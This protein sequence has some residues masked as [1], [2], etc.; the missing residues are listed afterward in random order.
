[1]QRNLF[2]AETIAQ[3]A[4]SPKPGTPE[5]SLDKYLA[6]TIRRV[7]LFLSQ[8]EYDDTLEKAEQAC[9]LLGVDNHTELFKAM[10]DDV[11]SRKL[12]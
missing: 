9:K 12:S 4:K 10:L 2:T 8:A 1:M 7:T 11:L 6:R 3:A 5:A